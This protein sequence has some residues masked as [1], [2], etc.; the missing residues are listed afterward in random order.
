MRLKLSEFG[1]LMSTPNSESFSLLGQ[2]VPVQVAPQILKKDVFFGTPFK[3]K[4]ITMGPLT[5]VVV[6]KSYKS[7][8]GLTVLCL[9]HTT[10]TE[11]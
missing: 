5:H 7:G 9:H 2:T 10:P 11:T 3:F 6:S 1:V 8:A 4:D